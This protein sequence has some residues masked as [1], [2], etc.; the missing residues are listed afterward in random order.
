[1]R[2]TIHDLY[3]NRQVVLEGERAQLRDR[4]MVEFPWLAYSPLDSLDEALELLACQQALDVE[5]EDDQGLVSQVEPEEP[6]G[7]AEG[8]GPNLV[9]D[10]DDLA[11][12]AVRFMTA[13]NPVSHDVARRALW[14]ED[15]DAVRAALVAYGEE[16]NEGNVRAV[17]SWIQ[18]A[19][20]AP[21][22]EVKKEAEPVEVIAKAPEDGDFAAEA[23]RRAF[24][25]RKVFHAEL[26]GKHSK[27]SLLATDPQSKKTF[28]LKPG[29]GGQSI[30][31]GATD[32]ASTQSQREAAFWAV[33]SLWGLGQYVPRADLLLVGGQEM[34]CIELLPRPFELLEDLD[35]DHPGLA[36]RL[37]RPYL[38]EG[39]L[40]YWGALDYVLG[41]P[42]RHGRNM[43]ANPSGLDLKP[44]AD[45]V[46]DGAGV[47]RLIDQG[48]AF[49]GKHFDPA[50][51][52]YSFVPFYLRAWAPPTF[53]KL[54]V[55][56]K[57]RYMPRLSRPEEAALKV[58]INSLDEDRT[59]KVITRYGVDPHPALD[60]LRRL[61][62]LVALAPADL[63]VNMMWVEGGESAAATLDGDQ[64]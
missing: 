28:L 34:A 15:G 18:I 6:L 57:L 32:S 52:R 8:P 35:E 24:R 26:G 13:G 36:R 27:G 23:V 49:A 41:N 45:Q 58:W 43:M 17:K 33:A 42:D 22:A 48:S 59:S 44:G 19:N 3:D 62:E 30:A 16:P 37:L 9:R 56:E 11:F 7:K 25:A 64:V 46:R 60:R 54:T 14:D 10:T 63:A 61:K 39:T 20:R 31:A 38:S 40:H 2:I 29:S 21:Q 53:N 1:M 5:V 51:D 50:H 55:A 4:L 12:E 47:V